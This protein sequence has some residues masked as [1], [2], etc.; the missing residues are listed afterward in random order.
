MAMLM[1][2]DPTKQLVYYQVISLSSPVQSVLIRFRQAGIGTYTNNV[3]KTA[4]I[5]TMTKLRDKMFAHS[6]SDHI[7]GLSF[8]CPTI[9]PCLTNISEGYK[10]L[11]QTCQLTTLGSFSLL[12]YPIRS[13]RG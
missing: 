12:P 13:I 7:K 5:E 10:F 2:D 8:S 9:S 1:K 4:A 3:N 11:M 6:L